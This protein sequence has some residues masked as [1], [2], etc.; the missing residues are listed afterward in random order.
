MRVGTTSTLRGTVGNI[1]VLYTQFLYVMG[2]QKNVWENQNTYYL[3]L[4]TYSLSQSGEVQMKLLKL[5][6]G[7]HPCLPFCT[8]A[9]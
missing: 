5:L 9:D 7:R 3:L 8:S 6:W 1:V 2:K 4:I